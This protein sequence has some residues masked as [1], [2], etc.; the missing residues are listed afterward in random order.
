[1]TTDAGSAPAQPH[2]VRDDLVVIDLVTR[3]RTGDKEAW[4]RSSSGSPR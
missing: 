2:P 1:M 4:V 3:A